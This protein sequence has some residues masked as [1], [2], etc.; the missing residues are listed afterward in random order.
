MH[1]D[2]DTANFAD[3]NTPYTSARNIDDVTEFLEQVQ[4]NGLNYSFKR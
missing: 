2:I 4:I 3:D 1:G